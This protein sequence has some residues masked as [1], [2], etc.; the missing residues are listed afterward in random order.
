MEVGD[1]MVT[2]LADSVTSPISVV[3]HPKIRK[4]SFSNYY[5]FW[6]TCKSTMARSIVALTL[7]WVFNADTWDVIWLG[8]WVAAGH[9][10]SINL[11]IL[12][13]Y[14]KKFHPLMQFVCA[15]LVKDFLVHVSG[16]LSP[17]S[18]VDWWL[19]Y[20]TWPQT[21]WH[22][23][24][25]CGFFHW[26]CRLVRDL[27]VFLEAVYHF[28][29]W[30]FLEPCQQRVHLIF[31]LHCLSSSKNGNLFHRIAFVGG[32]APWNSCRIKSLNSLWS[33]EC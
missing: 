31:F 17:S 13:F 30:F 10:I 26:S 19:P 11:S 14:F 16:P 20:L 33:L 5:Y 32:A 2:V 12:R 9:F 27:I 29:H 6:F 23:V 28:L 4:R 24:S 7:A 8:W 21:S 3:L 25:W 1:V 22:S 15:I 18:L